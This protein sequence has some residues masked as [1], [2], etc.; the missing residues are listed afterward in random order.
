MPWKFL[1][2]HGYRNGHVTIDD[3]DWVIDQETHGPPE[4]PAADVA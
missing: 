1:T 2:H 4:N 3:S